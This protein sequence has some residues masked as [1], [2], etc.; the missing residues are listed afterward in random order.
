MRRA[1]RPAVA[2][3][4]GGE[5]SPESFFSQVGGIALAFYIVKKREPEAV[6]C[7]DAI[8]RGQAFEQ[9][10][11]HT[12][13]K[14]TSVLDSTASPSFFLRHEFAIRRLHSL[15]GIIPLGVYMVIHLATGASLLNG[16]QTYQRAVYSIHSLGAM[17]PVVEW[18]LIL[19]PLLF[20]GL[21]GVWIVT[22][23]RSN[24]S[25][26][27]YTSNRRYSWQR[28]TGLIALV[29]LVVHVFH[30]HGWF[31]A[32][33]WLR[34]LR[35]VGLAAFKPYNA[36]STL[37]MAMDGWIW[38]AFY[39]VGVMATVYHLANGLWTA[40][41]TWGLWI[42]PSAQRRATKVCTAIGIIVALLGAGAWWAAVSPSG[43]EIR[44]ARQIEDD[45]YEAN[46]RTGAVYDLPE[47]RLDA[48]E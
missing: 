32:E 9:A 35:P 27:R 12:I 24:L 43:N 23:G 2:N 4:H 30:L 41:I 37:A 6:W 5:P 7:S 44:Q 33:P 31:H 36:A 22:T 18:L 21:L 26:Y 13:T 25:H 20:H 39:F 34:L 47:K 38:P 16:T 10:T 19:V 42:S 28:W 1:P 45:M 11:T 3:R 40:G 8:N 46:L 15:S 17:L 29:F 48:N 14:T